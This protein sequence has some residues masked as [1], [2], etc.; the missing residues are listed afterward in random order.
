MTAVALR[1]LLDKPYE[2]LL[3]LEKSARAALAG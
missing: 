3:E 1:S 2:L